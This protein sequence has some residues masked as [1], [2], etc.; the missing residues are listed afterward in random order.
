MK[1][2]KQFIFAST[3]L[4]PFFVF[5]STESPE[6][7][8]DLINRMVNLISLM[9]PVLISLAV[10]IFLYG[11]MTYIWN[12]G[13]QAKREEGRNFII[14]GIIGLFVMVSVWGLV[15]LLSDT[16]NLDTNVTIDNPIDIVPIN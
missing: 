10:L 8:Q 2:I 6:N 5:A 12:G 11:V 16:F 4:N 13:N 14:W 15:N 9:V 1:K 7:F 3:F